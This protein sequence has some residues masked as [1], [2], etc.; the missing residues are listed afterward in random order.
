MQFFRQGL[1]FFQLLMHEKTSVL[2]LIFLKLLFYKVTTAVFE[3]ESGEVFTAKGKREIDPGYLSVY[4]LGSV[5][6]S[7]EYSGKYYD[8]G[9]NHAD[10]DDESRVGYLD[11][12]EL[13]P[14]MRCR[15]A[16]LRLRQGQT[17]PPGHLTEA[18]LI[19]LM[20]KNG[21]GLLLISPPSLLKC[22]VSIDK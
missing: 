2:I 17:S 20:E 15:V 12:P 7:A 1:L 6:S 18:E 14:G 3:S 21:I 5:R 13:H 8:D 22:S 4:S 19:G 11:L 10:E 9:D 16:N